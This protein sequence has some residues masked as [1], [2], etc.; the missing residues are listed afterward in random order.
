MIRSKT[1]GWRHALAAGLVLAALAAPAAAQDYQ[2]YYDCPPG[3]TLVPAYYAPGYACVAD[4]YL[5]PS[6][7][8]AYPPFSTSVFFLDRFHRLHRV[9]RFHD[10]HGAFNRSGMPGH[11]AMP[12][13]SAMPGHSH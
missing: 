5:Y 10:H 4:A 13:H 9:D 1:M 11:S 7:Y 12:P 3:F 6:P 8:Y 2:A